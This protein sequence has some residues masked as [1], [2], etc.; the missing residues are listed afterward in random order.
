MMNNQ[1]AYMLNQLKQNPLQFLAQR[2]LN[3]PQN[4]AGN[5]NDILNYLVSSGKVSQQQINNAYQM[6]K[7]LSSNDARR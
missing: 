1:F 7:Q 6:A 2:N 4:M 3:I 5:P